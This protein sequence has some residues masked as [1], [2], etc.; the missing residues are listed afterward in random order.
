MIVSDLEDAVRN[1]IEELHRFFV[2]W[3]KGVA[4]VAD[5]E[6]QLAARLDPETQYIT[7]GANPDFSIAVGEVKIV[8]DLGDH[9][10]ATYVERQKGAK[11]S[12]RANNARFTTALLTKSQPFRWLHIHETWLPD[13]E[14]AGPYDF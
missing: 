12:A 4:D 5:L 3:F 6:S 11:N 1:E 7:H 9:L 2:A 10:L 14:A 13:A 8:R